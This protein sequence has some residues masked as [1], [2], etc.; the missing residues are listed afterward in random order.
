VFCKQTFS[1]EEL[2]LEKLRAC[3]KHVAFT[4]SYVFRLFSPSR[5]HRISRP[6]IKTDTFFKLKSFIVISCEALLRPNVC[7]SAYFRR[8]F[9]INVHIVTCVTLDG[10]LDWRLDLLTTYRSQLQITNTIA[11]FHILQITT[12]HAKSVQSA[13]SS[14]VPW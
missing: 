14:P 12:A 8:R 3:L 6:Y 9:L 2:C 11:N 5:S 1:C 10:V 7:H 13:L 4:L